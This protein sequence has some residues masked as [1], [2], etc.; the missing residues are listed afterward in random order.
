MCRSS[1]KQL[2]KRDRAV[3]R[4]IVAFL[5]EH[6]A[7][8]EDPRAV[9]E[10]HEGSGL[11][12]FWKY[13]VGDWRLI[14]QIEDARITVTVLHQGQPVR[15]LPLSAPVGAATPSFPLSSP[16]QPSLQESPDNILQLM[17]HMAA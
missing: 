14:F 2:A 17:G 11:E 9:G 3:A 6:I 13:R 10:A 4:R 7:V 1:Q 8:L 16:S 15:G 5:R 12:D